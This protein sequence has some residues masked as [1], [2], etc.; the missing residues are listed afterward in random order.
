MKKLLSEVHS[1]KYF[2][3]V[4]RTILLQFL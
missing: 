3:L 1:K 4:L 2:V